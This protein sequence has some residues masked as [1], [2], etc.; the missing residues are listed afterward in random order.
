M[1]ISNLCILR[2]VLRN[3]WFVLTPETLTWYKDEKEE[4]KMYV[5]SLN[6]LQLRN[7][8]QAFVSRRIAIALYNPDRPNVY[9][10]RYLVCS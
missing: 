7:I 3:Y 1:T 9:K 10:V 5:L 6:G 2:G 8:K 4:D